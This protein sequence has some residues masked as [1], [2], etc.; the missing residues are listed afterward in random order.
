MVV[1]ASNLQY[2]FLISRVAFRKHELLCHAVET[3]G[4]FLLELRRLYTQ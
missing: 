3:F 1:L 4:M 2:F